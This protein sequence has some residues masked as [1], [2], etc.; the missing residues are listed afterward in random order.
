MRQYLLCLPLFLAAAAV[1]A[2]RLEQN[3][4]DEFTGNKVERTS[5]EILV[6]NFTMNAFVAV[7]N[8][9]DEVYAL[10]LKLMLSAA[11]HSIDKD[12][13]FY[14]KLK[15]GT[16]VE[17]RNSEYALSCTGCG[18]RGFSGSQ[19][20]GTLTTWFLDNDKIEALRASPVASIR[21][22]TSKGYIQSEVKEARANIL[23]DELRL[24]QQ[25]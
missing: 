16:I 3:E 8:I 20:P 11:V 4:V 1:H 12:D 14:L 9:D 5:Y 25:Q 19:A 18:A 17:L 2:Q 6:Q 15:D 7:I 13:I 10:K 23:S 22:Y 24:V 21:I